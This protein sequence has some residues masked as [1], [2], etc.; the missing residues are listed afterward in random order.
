M[1][2]YN[3]WAIWILFGIVV[4]LTILV[5]ALVWGKEGGHQSEA[6]AA[7]AYFSRRLGASWVATSLNWGLFVG[8][9]VGLGWGVLAVIVHAGLMLL[10]IALLR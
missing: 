9:T 6:G 4:M 10:L 7:Y 8:F 1:D 5:Y 2:N 3:P